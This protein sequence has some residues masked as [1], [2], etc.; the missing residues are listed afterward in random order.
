MPTEVDQQQQGSGD[1]S[2]SHVAQPTI[3]KN[4]WIEIERYNGLQG[5]LQQTVEENKSLKAQL[6]DVTGKSEGELA[7]LKSERD[8]L[9]SFKTT[10]E[11]QLASLTQ[12]RDTFKT[13]ATQFQ[14][15]LEVAK[16][17]L[18]P[19]YQGLQP[20]HAKGLLAVNGKSG[21]DL[22]KFLDEAVATLSSQTTQ[23]VQQRLSG[24]TPET[25]PGN[26]GQQ[27]AKQI[28]EQLFKTPVGTPEYQKLFSAWQAAIAKPPTA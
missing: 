2:D 1:S 18:D 15:D 10:L 24:A 13:Q 3:D 4:K 20:L 11:Q 16:T 19:K 12:E 8:T 28:E 25:P 22:M 17:I 7:T 5:K 6:H 21:E 26:P 23:Q 14:S 27:T 9:S